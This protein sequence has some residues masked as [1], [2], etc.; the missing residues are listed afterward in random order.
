MSGFLTD[1][2]ILMHQQGEDGKAPILKNFIPSQIGKEHG[3]ISF[4]LSSVGYDIRL[5]HHSLK[6][7]QP[8]KRSLWKEW[9]CFLT[10][11]LFFARPRWVHPKN[12]SETCVS[13]PT[14]LYSSSS[15]LVFDVT[16]ALR[17]IKE[18]PYGENV[19]LE[20]IK[21]LESGALIPSDEYSENRQRIIKGISPVKDVE[22]IAQCK[23]WTGFSTILPPK[24]YGLG[25]SEEE[26]HMPEDVFG[27]A[28]NK[29]SLA[30]TGFIL[31][32]TPLEPNWSGYLT[33]EFY[34]ATAYHY[35]LPL[36]EGVSQI[37]FCRVSRPMI[38]YADRKGHYQDQ[39]QEV[40]FAKKI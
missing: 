32:V 12:F 18:E 16:H 22:L 9:I 2:D 31:N 3:R 28:Y 26:F 10:F 4:G 14:V 34:N 6:I 29:S 1:K 21:R 27:I 8:K 15:G 11:G 23:K 25:V 19:F 20:T 39:P 24:T 37:L 17:W 36:G 33:V 7:F 13:Q 5:N 35:I 30:R 40:V 38:T